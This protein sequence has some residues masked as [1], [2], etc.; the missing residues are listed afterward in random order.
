MSMRTAEVRQD[1]IDAWKE[2]DEV[3]V[4]RVVRREGYHLDPQALV[5]VLE[6]G[7]HARIEAFTLSI[8][9]GTRDL[10][11]SVIV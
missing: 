2:Y 1:A 6:T 10:T 9:R 11:H 3:F 7:D 5:D 8:R 4:G